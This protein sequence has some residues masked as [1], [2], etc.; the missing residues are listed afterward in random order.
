MWAILFCTSSFFRTQHGDSATCKIYAWTVLMNSWEWC[1]LM[2]KHPQIVPTSL[3]IIQ[4]F[5][6]LG[7]PHAFL[8]QIICVFDRGPWFGMLDDRYYW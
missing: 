7:M 8:M 2:Y 4:F 1:A 5:W 6:V 3:S